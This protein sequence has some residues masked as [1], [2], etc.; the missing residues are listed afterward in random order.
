MGAYSRQQLNVKKWKV[1]VKCWWVS[2]PYTFRVIQNR[3]IIYR[4]LQVTRKKTRGTATL[5]KSARCFCNIWLLS[6]KCLAMCCWFGLF[7]IHSACAESVS[8]LWCD[9]TT[10]HYITGVE[11]ASAMTSIKLWRLSP[12]LKYQRQLWSHKN[13]AMKSSL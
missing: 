7:S 8:M 10:L 3:D 2:L 6:R 9:A 1:F 13:N 5:W 11:I 12:T 4:R